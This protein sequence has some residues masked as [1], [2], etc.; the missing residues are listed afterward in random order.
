[1]PIVYLDEISVSQRGVLLPCR[2]WENTIVAGRSLSRYAH[3]E[4]EVI[5]R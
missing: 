5:V 4:M 1:M 3:V 2:K